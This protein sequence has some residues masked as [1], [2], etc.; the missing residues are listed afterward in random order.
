MQL[1][2]K[3]F[4]AISAIILIT[5]VATLIFYKPH[6]TEI[7]KNIATEIS[8]NMFLD[9]TSRTGSDQSQ[10]SN[11]I[12]QNTHDGWEFSYT[13]KSD[14]SRRIGIFVDKFGKADYSEAP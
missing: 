9:Y 2:R 5:I 10:F 8:N 3:I 7:D 4:I 6:S 1:K 11:V 12:I 14:H 13:L